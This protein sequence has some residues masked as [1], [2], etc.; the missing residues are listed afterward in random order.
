MNPDY[1]AQK[2]FAIKRGDDFVRTVIAR[3]SVDGDPVDL[4]GSTI[5]SQARRGAEVVTFRTEITDAVAGEF[6]WTLPRSTTED[7]AVGDWRYD[8]EVTDNNDIRLTR[9][10]GVFSVQ[11][12][13][14]YG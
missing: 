14:T 13:Q 11:A 5:R 3:A 6:T 2:D 12:D 4:T 10:G 9:V 1:Y 7:M 8:L